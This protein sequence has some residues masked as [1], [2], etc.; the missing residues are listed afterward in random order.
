M[1]LEKAADE[2]ME[3]SFVVGRILELQREGFGLTDMVGFYRTHSQSRVIEEELLRCNIPY[4][5][6]GGVKFY[7]RKEIKD[8]I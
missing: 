1:L 6:I 5:I 4:R 2:R 7:A 3:A 8:L